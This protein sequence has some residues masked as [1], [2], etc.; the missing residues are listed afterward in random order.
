MP[1][2]QHKS[3]LDSCEKTSKWFG[4]HGLLSFVFLWARTS[5]I[6]C[7]N[8][9]SNLSN[10]QVSV[11]TI[12]IHLEEAVTICRVKSYLRHLPMTPQNSNNVK[13]AGERNQLIALLLCFALTSQVLI[14]WLMLYFGSHCPEGASFCDT[15]QFYRF[16]SK[17]DCLGSS[18][19]QD[20]AEKKGRLSDASTAMPNAA[21][22]KHGRRK[23]TLRLFVPKMKK[24]KMSLK[25]C[26][27]SKENKLL[28]QDI[29]C[30][31]GCRSF[32]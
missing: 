16:Q 25:S 10:Y 26:A 29:V 17:S 27:S 8:N 24:R 15:G 6:H 20:K 32:S 31:H 9:H 12:R 28:V 7:G 3:Y 1:G 23:S 22:G 5:C 18:W 4:T 19:F 11:H 21:E 2:G 13:E 30:V 14:E